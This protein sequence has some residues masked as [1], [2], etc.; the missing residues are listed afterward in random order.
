[1]QVAPVAKACGVSP[2]AVQQIKKTTLTARQ[3]LCLREARRSS[4]SGGRTLSVAVR[5]ERDRG[6]GFATGFVLGGAIFGALGFI[7]A[8]QISAALLGE[9]QKLRLPR[10][11]DEPADP[12]LTK[13]NLRDKIA[14]LNAAIDEISGQLTSDPDTGSNSAYAK[15]TSRT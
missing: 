4:T 2:R 7:F 8:P 3:P 1:M 15:E 14:Q 11:M 13:E 6:S 12:E 9:D 10:F 5:A